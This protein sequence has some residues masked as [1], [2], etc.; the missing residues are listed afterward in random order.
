MSIVLLLL[1]VCD[2]FDGLDFVQENHFPNFSHFLKMALRWRGTRDDGA[3]QPN[4]QRISSS[5]EAREENRQE[6]HKIE[7]SAVLGR[8][9]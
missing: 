7:V 1:Q 9:L 5:G 3:G 8:I 6:R 2:C 4:E